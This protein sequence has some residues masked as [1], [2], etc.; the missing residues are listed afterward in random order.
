M[1][2]K[3]N[4]DCL[5]AQRSPTGPGTRHPKLHMAQ[6]RDGH[7]ALRSAHGT[8]EDYVTA[9][10]PLC[11]VP[12]GSCIKKTASISICLL[13][14]TRCDMSFGNIS[15]HCRQ[16]KHKHNS[17]TQSISANSRSCN[18]SAKT[19]QLPVKKRVGGMGEATKLSLIMICNQI[20]F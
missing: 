20:Y 11:T 16:S 17:Y 4:N 2:R 8:T 14:Q 18:Q 7:T 10:A 19:H 3:H 6:A 5:H 9:Q 15:G 13:N 12:T 1:N